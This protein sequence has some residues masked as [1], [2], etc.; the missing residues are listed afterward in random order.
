M[1]PR[2]VQSPTQGRGSSLASEGVAVTGL[3]EALA[4]ARPLL[5]PGALLLAS[6]FDGTLSRLVSDPWGARIIPAAQRALRQLAVGRGVH[7]ALITGR[8][9][10]DVAG[11]ARI[12]GISYRGDHGSERAEAARGFRPT[13]LFGLR[14]PA[15]DETIRLA[16]RLAHEVPMAVP[17]PWLV[18]EHKGASITFHFR[19]APDVGVARGR[20]IEAIGAVDPDELLVR[21][22][23]PRAIELRP[24]DASTKGDALVGLIQEHRP[25]SVIMLGDDRN[26]A[27]A[28]DVLRAARD[29]GAIDGLAISV[30]SHPDVSVEVAPRAD[31][32]LGSPDET[33]RFLAGLARTS[34]RLDEA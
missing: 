20:V 13:S 27:L 21:S 8:T 9:V 7:V 29:R 25:A 19:S 15:S 16:E 3:D 5:D 11:R 17:E 1:P 33:A 31:L 26:D 10:A 28:F 24:A 14:E 34:G 18:V 32:A 2:P 22:G 23:G 30:A 6:D 4:R 12:G